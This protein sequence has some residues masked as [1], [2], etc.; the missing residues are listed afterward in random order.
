[1]KDDDMRQAVNVPCSLWVDPKF[2]AL[3]VKSIA[4]SSIGQA[5]VI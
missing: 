5:I 2:K 1:M 3:S 4:Q